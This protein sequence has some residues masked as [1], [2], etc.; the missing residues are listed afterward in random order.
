MLRGI[1]FSGGYRHLSH[2]NGTKSDEP[3]DSMVW[4]TETSEFRKWCDREDGCISPLEGSSKKYNPYQ[5]CQ[6]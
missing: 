2:S 4:E 5:K 1:K 3:T 6:A